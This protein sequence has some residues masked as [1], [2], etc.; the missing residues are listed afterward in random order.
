LAST[1]RSRAPCQART[2]S[3]PERRSAPTV[4]RRRSRP[5]TPAWRRPRGG[6]LLR[7]ARRAGRRSCAGSAPTASPLA[8]P[9]PSRRPAAALPLLAWQRRPRPRAGSARRASRR[10]QLG[11]RRPEAARRARPLHPS[12]RCRR[13]TRRAPGPGVA[14]RR[15]RPRPLQ[16]QPEA[17][18]RRR[19]ALHAYRSWTDDNG[20][21]KSTKQVFGRDLRAAVPGVR[22]SQIGPIDDRTRV[23]RGVGLQPEK[24]GE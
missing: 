13:G 2:S 14:G 23:Y 1:G 20:R 19:H 17:R 15:L 21:V 12:A 10:P 11:T 22:V 4:R 24:R 7:R 5:A 16:P 6:A 9:S 8:C 3:R 18:G